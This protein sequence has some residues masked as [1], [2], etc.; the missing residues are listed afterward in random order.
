MAHDLAAALAGFHGEY[1]VVVIDGIDSAD[2]FRELRDALVATS[3]VGM[4][5]GAG[6]AFTVFVE[7]D[8]R[9]VGVLVS[10]AVHNEVSRRRKFVQY[11]HTTI[12][13]AR[14]PGQMLVVLQLKRRCRA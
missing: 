1:G 6:T 13:A 12:Q 5:D 2:R 7:G 8:R 14:Q 11:V 10:Q 3:H 4:E 9:L